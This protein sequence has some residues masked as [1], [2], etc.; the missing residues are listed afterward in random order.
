[1]RLFHSWKSM[2]FDG[3][4]NTTTPRNNPKKKTLIAAL[5]SSVLASA[6]YAQ[7]TSFYFTYIVAGPSADSLSWYDASPG[8]AYN[9]RFD[10]ANLGEI[11]SLVI[12]GQAATSQTHAANY[13]T[14]MG[15]KL[16]GQD[17]IVTL[18]WLGWNWSQS[19]YDLN[20]LGYVDGDLS[21]YEAHVSNYNPEDHLV[22][23]DLSQLSGTE[24]TLGI[25][26]SPKA[27]SIK[28]TT[29]SMHTTA[30]AGITTPPLSRPLPFPSRRHW[31]CWVLAPWRRFCVVVG[32]KR[33]EVHAVA[34]LRGRFSFG[35]RPT[36]RSDPIAG[37]ADLSDNKRQMTGGRTTGRKVGSMAWKIWGRK[38][39]GQ[40]ILRGG[41]EGL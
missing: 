9:P 4:E 29:P 8:G 17:H 1:M 25:G 20:Y 32:N 33:L 41:L 12:G 35:T 27:D 30:T 6:V 39:K 22:T 28:R 7:D 3:T 23:V 13:P 18:D 11:S 37:G 2:G 5:F 15:Y 36:R 40:L 10:G 24:H 21:E 34:A 26:S 16:D 38:E 19:S 14:Y 31:V